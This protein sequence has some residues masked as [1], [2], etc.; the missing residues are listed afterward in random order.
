MKS[1][2]LLFLPL[3]HPVELICFIAFGSTSDTCCLV[4]SIAI[5]LKCFFEIDVI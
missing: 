4:K 1:I 2:N 5:T 3:R